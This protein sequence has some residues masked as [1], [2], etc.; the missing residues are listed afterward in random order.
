[1]MTKPKGII[2]LNEIGVAGLG[3]FFILLAAMNDP[4]RRFGYRQALISWVCRN[5]ALRLLD[6]FKDFLRLRY[7][8]LVRHRLCLD[9]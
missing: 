3:R 6:G 2:Y 9:H 8:F 1:M 7:V 4:A 5:G